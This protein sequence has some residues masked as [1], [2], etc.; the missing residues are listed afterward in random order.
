MILMG[1]FFLVGR[2]DVSEV[3]LNEAGLPIVDWEE[4][5]EIIPAQEIVMPDPTIPDIDP[6][7]LPPI[8]WEIEEEINHTTPA[9]WVMEPHEKQDP[10]SEIMIEDSV[11]LAV[12]NPMIQD[13][14]LNMDMIQNNNFDIPFE[15]YFQRHFISSDQRYVV[16]QL[17]TSWFEH[18][19]IVFWYD[20]KKDNLVWLTDHY[21]GNTA[22]GFSPNEDYYVWQGNC[23]E[24]FCMISVEDIETREPV[25][26]I[27]NDGSV[28]GR[29]KKVNFKHWVSETEF[30]YE[31]Q[32]YLNDW[33]EEVK[34]ASIKK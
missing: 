16:G 23:F 2:D 29:N 4:P 21:L 12:E 31:I 30:K 34:I 7:N 8:D 28:D 26:Q 33:A 13:L 32:S 9:E 10:V 1:L 6:L 24:G 5:G 11:V 20:V 19:A 18:D 3:E 22:Y 14:F 15:I 17:S 27:N 25:N